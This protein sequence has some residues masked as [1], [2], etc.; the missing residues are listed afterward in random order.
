MASH[1]PGDV[2]FTA[3]DNPNRFVKR[4]G[5]GQNRSRTCQL[6]RG[7]G[8]VKVS[9]SIQGQDRFHGIDLRRIDYFRLMF[10]ECN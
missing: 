6:V 1:A 4:K 7:S 3:P 10:L 5:H 9:V 8:W 2:G